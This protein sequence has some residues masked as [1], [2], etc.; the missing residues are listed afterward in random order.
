LVISRDVSLNLLLR[1]PPTAAM[2][3][4][5]HIC[6]LKLILTTFAKIQVCPATLSFIKPRDMII[7]EVNLS[8][9]FPL[10]SVAVPASH[11]SLQKTSQKVLSGY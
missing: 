9:Y 1:T 5:T 3:L 7:A 2:L 6:E 4:D 10:G 11:D 8:S